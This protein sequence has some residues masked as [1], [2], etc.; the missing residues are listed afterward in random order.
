LG[1]FLGS[2]VASKVSDGTPWVLEWGH[3]HVRKMGNIWASTH[4]DAHEGT[5][6]TLRA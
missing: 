6:G 3:R 2:A 1:Y 5:L 4:I